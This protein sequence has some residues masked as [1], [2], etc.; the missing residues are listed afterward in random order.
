MS[1]NFSDFKA[2]ETTNK[3]TGVTAKRGQNFNMRYRKYVSKAGKP[4]ETQDEFIHISDNLFEKFDLE[5][6]ALRQ[7]IDGASGQSYLAVVDDENATLLKR[8][9]TKDGEEQGKGRKFKATVVTDALAA[10]GLIDKSIIGDSQLLD[11]EVVAEDVVIGAGEK[12]FHAYQVLKVVKGA[13]VETG[14]AND[15]NDEDATEEAG[16]VQ[17]S[18]AEAFASSSEATQEAGLNDDDEF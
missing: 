8:S 1:L 12:A 13:E 5:N 4:D 7:I 17:H 10:E 11:V 14:S 6:R 3:R 2:I 16:D 18:E 15:A 9:K